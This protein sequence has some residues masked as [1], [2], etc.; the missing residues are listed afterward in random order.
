MPAKGILI[1]PAAQ[2]DLAA[3]NR[4]IEVAVMTWDLP[5]RVK[6]L[7]LPSYR[8]DSVDLDHLD[9]VLAEEAGYRVIGVA[10]WEP[11]AAK[12]LPA[13]TG[14]LSLH[15]IYVAPGHHHQGVGSALF[16]AAEKAVSRRGLDGLLVKAQP[17]STGF[18]IAQGM[19]RMQVEAFPDQYANS[20]WKPATRMAKDPGC[21]FEP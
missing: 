15:G 19:E 8:Y 13:G 11:V 18:F 4:V 14:A 3:I 20:F 16:K 9:I 1:R 17:G 10:A 21:R 7:S 2:K 6:R 5:E 12:A